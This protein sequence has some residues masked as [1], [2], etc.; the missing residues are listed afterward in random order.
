[1]NFIKAIKEFIQ[2][3]DSRIRTRGRAIY[4]ILPKELVI[5]SN[6]VD[7]YEFII[8]SES[9]DEE[10]QVIFGI[11]EEDEYFIGDCDCP[12]SMQYGDT[13][14][15]QIAV[16]LVLERQFKQG[17]IKKLRISLSKKKELLPDEK[18]YFITQTHIIS[19]DLL[20]QIYKGNMSSINYNYWSFIN[21]PLH[22]D[23]ESK[24]V[25]FRLDAKHTPKASYLDTK[26]LRLECQCSAINVNEVCKHMV[27]LF[28][29]IQRKH[30]NAY[31]RQYED[32][33]EEMNSLLQPYGITSES[34][35]AKEFKF[36]FDYYGKLQIQTT[37]DNFMRNSDTSKWDK[38][39]K[40]LAIV[41]TKMDASQAVQTEVFEEI[42]ICMI[43]TT[44]VE[45]SI[46]LNVLGIRKKKTSDGLVYKKMSF[47]DAKAMQLLHEVRADI[48]QILQFIEA[49]LIE[50][51]NG[52]QWDYMPSKAKVS[53]IMKL[54]TGLL[55]IANLPNPT[56]SLK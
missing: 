28:I 22:E 27:Q 5:E 41:S 45:E 52:N 3:S 15:H 17:E 1:M 8:K 16:A 4:N 32:M 40:S 31:F 24:S 47:R 20:R 49:N 9:S 2:E 13:C 23:K 29:V 19:D 7:E 18:G 21:L 33:S 37:P 51:G 48:A 34:K 30:S 35:L 43:C 44:S 56:F 54:K 55:A 50:L 46:K 25:W 26:Q 6:E 36:G 11:N 53:W 42:A 12:Y 38:L 14:K 10:Y 39:K